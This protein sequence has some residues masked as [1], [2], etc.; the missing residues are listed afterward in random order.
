MAGSDTGIWSLHYS[1]DGSKLLTSSPDGSAKVFDT[2]YGR[3]VNSM[4]GNTLKCYWA[5]WDEKSQLIATCGSDKSVY[6][7]DLRNTSKPLA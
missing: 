2:K 1:K 6:T 4:A 7:F 3:P 5:D